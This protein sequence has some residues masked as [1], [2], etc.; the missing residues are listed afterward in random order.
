MDI[1]TDIQYII[2]FEIFKRFETKRLYMPKDISS[3]PD[4]L[5][6]IVH[7]V[8]IE[9]DFINHDNETEEYFYNYINN[10]YDDIALHR[11]NS[12]MQ[13]LKQDYYKYIR[14]LCEQWYQLNLNT[15][16]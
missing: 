4:E 9:N 11:H 13:K 5:R 16:Y 3:G 7:G 8:L 1:N 15:F 12:T 10:L 6:K 2:L 14:E